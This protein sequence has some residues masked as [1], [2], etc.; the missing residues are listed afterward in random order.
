VRSRS[1]FL[2]SI[3]ACLSVS[4]LFLGIATPARA[5]AIRDLEYWLGDYGFTEAWNV[6]RGAGVIVSVIDSG[7]GDVADL[8]DAVIGGA[9]FSGLGSPDGRTP[10]GA[11]PDH[12]TLVA[13]LLAGRGTGGNNGVIGTAPEVSLLSASVALGVTTDIPSD[14]QIADAVR[15]SVD[16]GA[17]IINMSL[18]RNSLEWPRSWDDAFL[19]AFENDVV[20]VAA[21]GNRGTG[22]EEVGAPATIPGVLT[23][24]G[25]DAAGTAS[26]DASSQGIT[27]GV[28]A[29]GEE[30]V[31]VSASGQYM[32]W[33]G[34]SGAAP[35]VSGL[36]ALVRAS[37]PELNAANV[38]QRVLATATPVDTVPSPI[39]GYGLINAAAAVTAD[40]PPVEANPLGSL[41]EWI[42]LYR[43][44]ESTSTAT[45]GAT[46]TATPLP[47]PK[48]GGALSN[49]PTL[50]EVTQVGV[51]LVFLLGFGTLVVLGYIGVIRRVR[52]VRDVEETEDIEGE[53]ISPPVL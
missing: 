47:I 15:W 53:P 3:L 26:Y 45:P 20:I 40:V 22:T 50:F 4:T 11:S 17:S 1:R 31:G 44:A 43:R 27:I 21:A 42:R 37:H 9:D 14:Q 19:Y 30:L 48:D 34:S 46:S 7:I 51:P 29:S 8:G 16:N 24:A 33:S 39:Y 12:G 32:T 18:T 23:V 36:V 49:A 38:I 5:D 2:A 41:E 28:A 25:L 13:S 35:L 6:T 52:P 10:V